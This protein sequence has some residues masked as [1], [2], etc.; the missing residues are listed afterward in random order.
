LQRLVNGQP[1]VTQPFR[2]GALDKPPGGVN[3]LYIHDGHLFRQPGL[4]GQG[5][6]LGQQRRISR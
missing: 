6:H 2:Q 4:A 5:Q 3:T 1:P